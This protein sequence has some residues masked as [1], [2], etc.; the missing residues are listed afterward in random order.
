[1]TANFLGRVVP[2]FYRTAGKRDFSL[3]SECNNFHEKEPRGSARGPPSR[4]N[5]KLYLYIVSICIHDYLVPL[6]ALSAKGASCTEETRSKLGDSID[7]I[8]KA[9]RPWIQIT[10]SWRLSMLVT[11][12]TSFDDRRWCII[13]IL[14]VCSN[15]DNSETPIA[16]SQSSEIHETFCCYV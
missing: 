7:E 4:H 3:W 5:D 8:G 12:G 14:T 15:F 16:K 2:K 13:Q 10:F 9:C 6:R 11:V 1:M